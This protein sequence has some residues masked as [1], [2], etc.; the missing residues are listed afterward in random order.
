MGLTLADGQ[1]AASSGTILAAG[2]IERTVNVILTNTGTA[3]ETVIVSVSR[4]GGT[5]RRLIRIGV[6]SYESLYITGL[7]LDPADTIAAYTTNATTVDYLITLGSGPF[8]IVASSAVRMLTEIRE[9]LWS[10]SPR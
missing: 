3:T 10:L 1:L 2:S 4:A 7:P 5:A 8:T 6:E 9:L